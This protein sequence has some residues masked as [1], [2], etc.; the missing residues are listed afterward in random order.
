MTAPCGLDKPPCIK[1]H[2]I[3]K[4]REVQRT[5]ASFVA[6]TETD[7][8]TGVKQCDSRGIDHR[9]DVRRGELN[10]RKSVGVDRLRS[11]HLSALIVEWRKSP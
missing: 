4:L 2:G 8:G 5:F 10:H 1:G 6:I 7:P 11:S 9:N 3:G